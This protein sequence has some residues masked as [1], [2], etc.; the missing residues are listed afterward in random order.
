MGKSHFL[1]PAHLEERMARRA[2]MKIPLYPRSSATS[3]HNTLHSEILHAN[4]EVR[5]TEIHR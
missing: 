2:G 3:K 4:E 1:Y 5:I